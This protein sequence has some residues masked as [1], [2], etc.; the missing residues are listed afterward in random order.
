VVASSLNAE[1]EVDAFEKQEVGDITYLN[2]HNT[3]MFQ[4]GRSFS[5]NERHKLWFNNA[6]ESFGDMSDLSG[7][8]SPN[9]GRGVVAA[10]FD[11][12]G[13]VDLFVHNIQRERHALYR[14]ELGSAGG[15]IKVRLKATLG[16]YEAIGATVIA[17]VSGNSTAQVLSRGAGFVSCQ[18]PELVFG[19]GGAPGAEV[20]VRW[21]GG[22]LEEFG[23]TERNSRVLLVE[24]QGEA[25]AFAAHTRAL[26]DPLPRGFKI[27]VGER[28]PRL[29]VLDAESNKTLIDPVALADGGTLYI[30][31][32][33]SYC[34]SC[35]KELPDLQALDEKPG[36]RVVGISMDAPADSSAVHELLRKRG[37]RYAAFYIGREPTEGDGL[38]SI[39]EVIDI[40]RLPIPSTLVVG[41]DGIIRNI[42][43]GPLDASG[44]AS[45]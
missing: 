42:L 11:D 39:T 20:A 2:R 43:K 28:L 9:D 7:L 12:D 13:D 18:A 38:T 8:D 41:P 26:P 30:N 35:V 32:W 40:E 36:M 33:A 14:N 6:D 22:V 15:F 21:P 16:Q 17:T 34:G 44:Q 45:E 1:D 3:E 25:R 24:G 19:L 4:S 23:H 27:L 37:A 31:F 5:G 10:D 29:A